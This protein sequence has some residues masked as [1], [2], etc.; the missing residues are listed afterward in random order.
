M[1]EFTIPGEPKAQGRPR[2]STFGGFPRAIDPKE[3]RDF[4]SRVAYFGQNANFYE[5]DSGLRV[6][7][8][9][10][11]KR[12]KNRQ[13]KSDSV[14]PIRC[15]KKPDLDNLV[16]AIF[17]GLKGVCFRDDG[18]VGELHAQKF[19]HEI[20]GQPRTVVTLEVI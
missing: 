18:Q 6:R 7:V 5:A 20:N 9:F 13:K 15:F 14:D 8:D 17:D 2:F 1:I 19:Y 16:K 11:L 10:Y 12:P 3:S 4:K